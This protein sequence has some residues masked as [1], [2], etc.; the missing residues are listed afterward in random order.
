MDTDW[1][2]LAMGL[3]LIGVLLVIW[4]LND[5]L[6]RVISDWMMQTGP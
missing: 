4:L 3:T 1:K 2:W 5:Y 6:A